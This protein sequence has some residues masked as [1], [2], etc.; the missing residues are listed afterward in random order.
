[1]DNLLSLGADVSIS[2]ARGN[3]RIPMLHAAIYT[4]DMLRLKMTKLILEHGAS[5]DSI[6]LVPWHES[7]STTRVSALALAALVPLPDVMDLLVGKGA[8]WIWSDDFVLQR[9][10][11]RN[12]IAFYTKSITTVAARSVRNEY[13]VP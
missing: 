7:S 6:G 3:K 13:T 1:M 4:E 12:F 10:A 11:Q 8:A 5:L 2:I 9:L